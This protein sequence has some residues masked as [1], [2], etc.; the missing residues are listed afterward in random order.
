MSQ[1]CPYC[2]FS[3][4]DGAVVCGHCGAEK[5]TVALEETDTDGNAG[6]G[7]VV[8][9]IAA[10]GAWFMFGNWKA[11]GIGAVG[12]F[13]LGMWGDFIMRAGKGLVVGAI[14]AVIFYFIFS[15][16]GWPKVGALIG[17][18]MG[19]LGGISKETTEERWFR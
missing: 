7:I 10:V 5:R 4:P 1:T 3:I 6:V 18:A 14:C 8:A 13:V 16:F 15:F 2:R 11:V 17:F 9:I 19:F 12:G